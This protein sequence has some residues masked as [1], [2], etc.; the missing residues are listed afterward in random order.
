MK[1]IFRWLFVLA[2]V[3]CAGSMT[4]L[5]GYYAKGKEGS[6]EYG[7]LLEKLTAVKQ[8]AENPEDIKAQA[9]WL[10]DPPVLFV[11]FDGLEKVNKDIVAWIDF[12]GQDISYPVVRTEDNSYYLKYT[13]EGKKNSMGCVFEDCRNGKPFTDG[14]TIFYGHNMKN[15]SMFG[16]LKRYLEEEHYKQFPYFDVYTPD[17][18]YRCFIRACCRAPAKE[19]SYPV[20]FASEQEKEEFVQGMKSRGEYEIADETV[21]NAPLIMLST[22]VG[23]GNYRD[24]FVV[25]AQARKIPE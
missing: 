12:P 14:N 7:S 16:S 1:R 6:Q 23:G 20:G 24:R 4:L 13:F 9:D 2:L 17:G 3:V 19:E 18:T 21:P 8:P 5:Y 10:T 15:G 22:C 11:D 25:V